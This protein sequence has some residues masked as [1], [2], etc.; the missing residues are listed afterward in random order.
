MTI[1]AVINA[2]TTS[3]RLPRKLVIPFAG[4]TLIDIAIKKLDKMDFLA[5][6]YFAA[7]ED[8]L[9]DRAK[10]YSNIEILRRS[11]ESVLPGYGDHRV[12][13][14]HYEKIDSEYFIWM[15]P[16][17]PLLSADTLRR[18]IDYVHETKFNS[19]TSVIP[20]TDW[21]FDTEGNP[22]TNKQGSMV[23]TAHSRKFYKVAHAFHI[24]NKRFFLKDYQCWSMTRNDPALFEIP[25]EESFDV[26]TQ[27]EF[28]V[29]E[30]AYLQ[31][32]K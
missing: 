20:T 17:S 22:I 5:H 27:I 19:Y 24:F 9:I 18:A 26:N 15:N 30:A 14:A 4:T 8:E 23:S 25:E 6:R 2:R 3:S 29:A 16:C 12:I 31:Y 28:N 1:A 13:Y 11:P 32:S 7:A 21:I 10:H